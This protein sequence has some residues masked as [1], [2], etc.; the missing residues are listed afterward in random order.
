MLLCWAF[1]GKIR[2]EKIKI[3]DNGLR[4]AWNTQD[5]KENLHS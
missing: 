1:S 4:K 5:K 2:L 3:N